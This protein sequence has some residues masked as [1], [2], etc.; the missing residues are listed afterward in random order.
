MKSTI[1]TTCLVFASLA[2]P[3]A[4]Q[5]GD[6]PAMD[7]GG[8]LVDAEGMTLYVFD[9]D[10]AGGG[11]ACNGPCATN[12]PPLMAKGDASAAGDW[13][14]VTREDGAHQWAYK[15][16]PLYR[17]IKDAKAGDMTGDG[18]KGV[19]HVAKP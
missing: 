11:S 18:F 6:M 14:I 16:R 1:L 4:V 5:A 2:A 13:S 19:W 17:W 7:K 8:S 9:K 3:F 10:P 15:G 12:W